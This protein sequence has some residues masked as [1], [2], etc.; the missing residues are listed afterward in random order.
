MFGD[1]HNDTLVGGLGLDELTGGG[2][3]DTFTF[4]AAS[5]FDA[6][7]VIKDFSS[8]YDAIDI[9]DVLSGYDP[10]SDTITDFVQITDDGSDSTLVVDVD[11]GADNFVAI[12]LIDNRTGLTDE[13]ALETSGALITV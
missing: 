13:A 9:S 3:Y 6:V 7:D 4:L 2:G 5:S 12:A 8:T 10:L 1:N 11:G